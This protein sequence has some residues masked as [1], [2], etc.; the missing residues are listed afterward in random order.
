VVVITKEK[1]G[2]DEYLS[3]EI[4]SQREQKGSFKAE[5]GEK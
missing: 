4:I 1:D 3:Y 5:K 2:K